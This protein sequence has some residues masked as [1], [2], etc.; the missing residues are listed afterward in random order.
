MPKSS[1]SKK[2]EPEIAKRLTRQLRGRGEKEPK[3]LAYALL[4]KMGHM[5]DG[6][7]T[8][9]GKARNEMT[10]GERAK[11]RQAKYTGRKASD[12]TYNPKTNQATVKKKK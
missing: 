12:F 2:Q 6:K 4:N 10:P 1:K 3:E 11:D 5:K 9:K 7:L 8:P